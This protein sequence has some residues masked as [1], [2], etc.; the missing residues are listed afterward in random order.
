MTLSEPS[1]NVHD[2]AA[3]AVELSTEKNSAACGRNEKTSIVAA[4]QC[5]LS[6]LEEFIVISKCSEE[7]TYPQPSA[8]STDPA[9]LYS[10]CQ[11]LPLDGISIEPS[12]LTPGITVLTAAGRRFCILRARVRQRHHKTLFEPTQ[13]LG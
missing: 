4:S 9:L 7:N 13:S 6:G 11:D 1:A 3:D 10:N 12:P 2:E 8:L 5:C